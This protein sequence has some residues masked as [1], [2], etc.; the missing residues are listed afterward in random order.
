MI[1]TGIFLAALA[2]S[3]TAS[4]ALAYEWKTV[5]MTAQHVMV[6]DIAR[7]RSNQNFQ[8]VSLA[9]GNHERSQDGSDY[10]LHVLRVNCERQTIQR[11]STTTYAIEDPEPRRLTHELGD[12]PPQPRTEAGDLQMLIDHVCAGADLI[13]VD[14]PTLRTALASY[15]AYIPD[16]PT[17]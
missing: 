8:L 7:G 15:R 2:L 6:V 5:Q 10:T 4:G 13:G 14:H 1:G 3:G 9:V 16:T 12:E 11:I 17:P